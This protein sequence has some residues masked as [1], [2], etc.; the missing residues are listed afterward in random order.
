M[1][2]TRGLKHDCYDRAFRAR[3]LAKYPRRTRPLSDLIADYIL[4]HG[5][6]YDDRQIATRLR[7]KTVG[8]LKRQLQRA[9]ARGVITIRDG[10]IQL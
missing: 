7:Y 4:L 9:R 10:V 3:T 8:S 5:E 2:S 6:G 1:V